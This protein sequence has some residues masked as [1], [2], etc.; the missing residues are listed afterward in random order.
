MKIDKL[1]AQ[2][3]EKWARAEMFFGE[4][5]GTRRK[6]LDAEIM[7]KASTVP[8]YLEK[9]NR[10][11]E[12]QDFAEHADKAAKER[13]RLD[14]QKKVERNV[15]GLTTGNKQTLTTGVA[16]IV[17]AWYIANQTGYDVVI[18]DYTKK[19]YTDTKRWVQ[20]KRTQ[21]RMQKMRREE[22]ERMQRT[23]S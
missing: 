8:G 15:R 23:Q 5:A 20:S 14:R 7:Q 16:V 12:K 18:K 21:L 2:D 11:Y 17:T 1:A 9:F 4:G 22:Q 6:L 13:R 3:A 10:S 19:K